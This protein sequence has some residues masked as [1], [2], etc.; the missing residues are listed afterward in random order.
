MNKFY[1]FLKGT[2][3]KKNSYSDEKEILPGGLVLKEMTAVLRTILIP[4]IKTVDVKA[5]RIEGKWKLN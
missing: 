4:K 2:V 3:S 1:A 5:Q